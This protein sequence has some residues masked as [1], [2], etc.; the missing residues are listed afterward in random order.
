MLSLRIPT[1]FPLES[2]YYQIYCLSGHARLYLVTVDQNSVLRLSTMRS[3]HVLRR[4][5]CLSAYVISVLAL[6]PILQQPSNV[7]LTAVR[8]ADYPL[9]AWP[10]PLPW[11]LDLGGDLSMDF[12]R[13]GKEASPSRWNAIRGD[14]DGLSKSMEDDGAVRFFHLGG[15]NSFHRQNIV[16]DFTHRLEPGSPKLSLTDAAKIVK[17][18]NNCFFSYK[19]GPSEFEAEIKIRRRAAMKMEL[20]WQPIPFSNPWPE[21][22][23][24]LL[25]SSDLSMEIYLYGK[26]AESANIDG[27]ITYLGLLIL[28]IR[29]ER[30]RTGFISRDSYQNRFVSLDIEG[31][32]PEDVQVSITRGQIIEV[33]EAIDKM[34]SK[35]GHGP[36][37]LG[38]RVMVQNRILG[39]VFLTFTTAESC[40]QQNQSSN[41]TQVRDVNSSSLICSHINTTRPMSLKPDFIL[42]LPTT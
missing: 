30:P 24:R 28:S 14:L 2:V 37:E 11:T 23:W 33:L 10:L 5:V 3:T 38:A 16:V 1:W 20:F 25:L 6:T 26:D 13:Y 17:A 34:Y 32:V 22:P 21:L 40:D 35:L 36:R 8:L 42:S 15:L 29:G 9:S 12:Q 31:I 19:Y 4:P 39:K 7:S 27:V 18:T 41:T